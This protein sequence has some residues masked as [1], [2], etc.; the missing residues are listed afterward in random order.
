[1]QPSCCFHCRSDSRVTSISETPDEVLVGVT[2]HRVISL[3]PHCSTLSSAVHSYYYRHPLY[4]PCAGQRMRL[5]LIV[6][7]V[8]VV[9]PPAHGR[10]F[11]SHIP[12]PRHSYLLSVLDTLCETYPGKVLSRELFLCLATS[13]RQTRICADIMT[14]AS[15]WSRRRHASSRGNAMSI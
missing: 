14:S 5:L 3:C 7:K 15:W 8:S 11:M 9:W 2:L 12:L 13:W 1:M 4:L 6:K 10:L